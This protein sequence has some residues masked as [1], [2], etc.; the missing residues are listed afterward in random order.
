[1]EVFP[2]ASQDLGSLCCPGELALI[3]PACPLNSRNQPSCLISNCTVQSKT[4]PSPAWGSCIWAPRGTWATVGGIHWLLGFCL[5]GWDGQETVGVASTAGQIQRSD[6]Q[7]GQALPLR[8]PAPPTGS[9]KRQVPP[10]PTE[11]PP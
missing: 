10:A 4:L 3:A 6:H 7:L 8:L 1:M 9:G 5:P 2:R 11:A